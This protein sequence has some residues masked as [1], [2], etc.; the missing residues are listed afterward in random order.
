MDSQESLFSQDELERPTSP[1]PT[2]MTPNP[3]VSMKKTVIQ[4][5]SSSSSK[6]RKSADELILDAA[7]QRLLNPPQNKKDDDEHDIF[8][9][10]VASQL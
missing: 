3:T 10:Y 4:K 1:G 7:R 2:P 5:P 9:K 8:G 6:K